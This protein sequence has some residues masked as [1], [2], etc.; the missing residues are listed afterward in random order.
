[1]RT[2]ACPLRAALALIAAILLAAPAWA[3]V[4][5]ST[6]EDKPSGDDRPPVSFHFDEWYQETKEEE[7]FG[8]YGGPLVGYL[9]LDLSCLDPMTRGRG[10]D[11]FPEDLVVV[12]GLGGMAYRPRESEGFWALGG[13]GFGV[14][15]QKVEDGDLEATM[16]LGGG[17]LFLEFHQ[18]VAAKGEVFLGAMVG[19][20]AITLTAKGADLGLADGEDWSANRTFFLAYPYLGLGYAPAPW[21]RVTASGGWLFAGADLSGSDFE[22]EN[23]GMDM[24]DGGLQGGPQAM[25]SVVFGYW[26]A[27]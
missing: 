17:G 3:E 4:S 21:M 9:N 15:E 5:G 1:V 26:P 8:G 20:G 6:V 24:T 12:G 18:P 22:I 25:V 13:F 23:T 2:I 16:A 10:L 11:G 14:P 27:P 7:R 19:A